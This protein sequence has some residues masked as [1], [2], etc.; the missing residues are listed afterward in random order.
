MNAARKLLAQQLRKL[1]RETGLTAAT[2]AKTRRQMSSAE[3]AYVGRFSFQLTPWWE[4]F[5]DRWSQPDVRKGVSQKSA[6]GG[7]TQ[8]VVC[9]VLGHVAD[10]E[11]TTA[12]VMFSKGEMARDFDV[13]KFQPM[14]ESTPTLRAIIP[15]GSRDKNNTVRHK[16]FTGG[17]IKFI[18]GRSIADVKSTTAWRLIVEEPDDQPDNLQEQGDA[19]KLFE[20]RGKTIRGL[21]M[22]IGGT[23]SVKNHSQIES[24]MATTDQNHWVVPCPDCGEHQ[25]L[26]WEQVRWSDDREIEHP[27]YGRARPA[28]ARYVCKHCGSEWSNAAMKGAAARGRAEPSAPFNGS[29]GLYISDLYMPWAESSLERMVEKYLEAQHEQKVKGDTGAM[30]KFWN[31]QLGRSYE[32]KGETPSTDDLRTRGLAYEPLTVPA[33]ALV[34]TIGVDVQHDRLAVTVYGWGRGEESWLVLW[35]ELLGRPVDYNDQVWDELDDVL[36]GVYRHAFGVGLRI[37]GATVDAGDGTTADAVYHYVRARQTRA[38]EIGLQLMAGKGDSNPKAEIF[39]RPRGS[40]DSNKRNT[41]ASKFGLR[42]YM[43]GSSRAKDLILGE[44]GPGRLA[45]EGDGPGRMHWYAAV[46]S[47]FLPGLAAEVK[48]PKRGSAK[49]VWELSKGKR[50]EPLDCTIYALHAARAVKVHVMREQQWLALEA[51]IR[52]QELYEITVT[53]DLGEG[54]REI[55]RERARDPAEAVQTSAHETSPPVRASLKP[56]RARKRSASVAAIARLQRSPASQ[57]SG[58]DEGGRFM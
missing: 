26:E 8:S 5:L 48:V 16:R 4:W 33:P 11:K 53:A 58:G 51:Q 19:I 46:R 45:L 36:F 40:I 6:Q 41:K 32:Y 47:D 22:L 7:W 10:V 18:S 37:R 3:G 17:W 21:K 1:K 35:D 52:Q 54:D 57:G 49:K 42:P 50:N 31:A 39:A 24:E 30:I 34:L 2:W 14:I 15:T 28:S 55:P 23:P 27:V 20:E 38:R 56:A 9:N 25:A 43:V 44:A 12:I 29:V 13:E